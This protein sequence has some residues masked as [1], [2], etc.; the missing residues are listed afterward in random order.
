[1]AERNKTAGS[2]VIPT[3]RYSD[4]QAAIVWLC[5]TFGFEKQLLV[6]DQEGGVAHAQLT[7]SNGMIM[8][9]AAKNN[10]FNKLVKSPAENGGFGSQSVYIVVADVDHHYAK[11]VSAGAEIVIDIKDEDYGGRGY[12]CRDLEGHVW[13]FGSYDPWSA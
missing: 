2:F 3:L 9:G 8:L 6:L 1:M 7:Y 13:C 4:G 5:E 12:A 11:A 10:E